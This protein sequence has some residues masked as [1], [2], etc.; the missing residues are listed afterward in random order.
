MKALIYVTICS[1]LLLASCSKNIEPVENMV[2]RAVIT[3]KQ[4][5]PF[6]TKYDK[7][8]KNSTNARAA[9][10]VEYGPYTVTGNL[11]QILSRYKT[12]L[13]T[14]QQYYA[15]GVYFADIYVLETNITIPAGAFFNFISASKTGYSDWPSQTSGINVTQTV[16]SSGTTYN[17]STNSMVPLYDASGRAVNQY[18]LPNNQDLTGGTFTYSYIV[19]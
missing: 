4:Q 1:F 6:M 7:A 10:F 3:S 11:R 5:L 14:N 15:P 19:R 12:T 9:A 2:E 18:V 16:N 13:G 8:R 17:I